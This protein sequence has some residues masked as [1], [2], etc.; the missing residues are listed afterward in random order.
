M[1]PFDSAARSRGRL[2]SGQGMANDWT[3]EMQEQFDDLKTDI[4]ARFDQQKR[5]AQAQFD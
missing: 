1:L 2:P 3:S 4:Q 5:G